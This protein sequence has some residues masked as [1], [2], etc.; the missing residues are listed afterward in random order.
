[1]FIVLVICL[2]RPRPPETTRSAILTDEP[3]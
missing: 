2:A 3:L 1:M